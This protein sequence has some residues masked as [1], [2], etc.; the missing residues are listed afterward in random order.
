MKLAMI[1][2][3]KLGSAL[4]GGIITKGVLTPGDIGVLEAD[5]ERAAAVTERFGVEQLQPQDL[6]GT[7]T[8]LIAV[9]PRHFRTVAGWASAYGAA[10]ISTMAGVTLHTLQQNL[11]AQRVVRVMPNLAATIGRAQTALTATPEAES[12]G[13]LAF[14]TELFGAVGDTYHLPER[15]FDAFTGMSASGPAYVALFAEALADGGVRMGL[16]RAVA[17]ELTQKLLVASGELLAER[18]HPALLKDEVS[19]PGGTTIA[20]IQ[21]LEEHGLR[22]SVIQAV[23]AA[24][25]RGQELGREQEKERGE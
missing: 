20:G 6:G 12:A 17:A 7:S 9:Q 13:D 4:L 11:Q 8:I 10:F 1:G 15:L 23:M 5:S 25:L 14:A 18:A 3:G 21:A 16:P 2:T 22:N 24:T 19:S